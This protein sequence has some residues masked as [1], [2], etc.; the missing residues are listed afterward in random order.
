[1]YLAEKAD[2]C[3]ITNYSSSI[4]INKLYS[5]VSSYVPK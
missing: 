2:N 5:I 4:E 3:S 1:M